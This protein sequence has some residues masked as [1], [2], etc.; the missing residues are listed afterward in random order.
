MLYFRRKDAGITIQPFADTFA[1]AIPLAP[2]R[3]TSDIKCITEGAACNSLIRSRLASRHHQM[4]TFE[5]IRLLAPPGVAL[6]ACYRATTVKTRLEPFP[7]YCIMFV[8][9]FHPKMHQHVISI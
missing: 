3:Y 9:I 1:F 7:P 6:R 8:N 4:I 2:S 5:L